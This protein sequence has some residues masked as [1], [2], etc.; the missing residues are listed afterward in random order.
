MIIV[1]LLVVLLFQTPLTVVVEL[2]QEWRIK[3]R[4]RNHEG[5][6]IAI[7]LDL[8]NFADTRPTLRLVLEGDPQ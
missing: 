4:L 5:W 7:D 8:A 1:P 3:R 2:I 6:L